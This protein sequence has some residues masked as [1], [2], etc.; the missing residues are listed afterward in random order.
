MII[1]ESD[2]TQTPDEKRLDKEWAGEFQLLCTVYTSHP[3]KMQVRPDN[4]DWLDAEIQRRNHPTH[5]CRR[6]TGYKKSH[7]I[8]STNSLRRQR[9]QKSISQSTTY[10][11]SD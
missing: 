7:A 2:Q 6:G 11:H 9:A 3:V 5:R 1:L 8:S 4:G 10:M